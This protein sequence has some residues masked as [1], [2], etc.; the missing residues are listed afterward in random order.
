MAKIRAHRNNRSSSFP[1][2][3]KRIGGRVS[4]DVKSVPFESFEGYRYV[5]N[6]VDHHSRLGICYFMRHKSQVSAFFKRYCDELA[7]YGFRVEH[8]QSDRG[9]EYFSQEGD[10]IAGK[11]RSLGELDRFCAAQTP[12]IPHTVA[13][14]GSK[15]KLAEVWFRDMFESADALLFEARL[16]LAFW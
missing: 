1:V 10:L 4:S 3:T 2:A 14:V 16:P 5:V 8:L 9:S 11:D 15:E 6:F 13:P 7:H 12:K